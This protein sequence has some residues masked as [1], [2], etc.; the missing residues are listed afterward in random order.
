MQTS[1]MAHPIHDQRYQAVAVRLKELR[2]EGGWLQQDIADR[3][4]RS[5][6]FVS[7]YESGSRRIDLIELLDIL[8]ALEADPHGFIDLMLQRRPM[9]ALP[10]K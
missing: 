8:Q 6:T 5:Q 4:G 10:R 1:G 3:L 2:E 7:K 9:K